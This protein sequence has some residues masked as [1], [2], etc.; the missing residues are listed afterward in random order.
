VN[1]LLLGPQG[2]GK[3][4]QAVRISAEYGIPH[5]STGNMLR[6]AMAAGNELGERVRPIYEAGRLVPDELMIELIRERLGQPDTAEGFVL[7]GF[8]RTLPQAEALDTML[9]GI[10]R[11]L[12]VILELIVPEE[13]S[14]ERMLRRGELEGR[15]DDT[16]EAIRR[17]LD[18]YYEQS[19]PVADHY[20][21][22]GAL[23]GIHGER[24]V[25][26]VFAE[27]QDV[28]EQ[29]RAREPA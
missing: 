1:I 29:A 8:P 22:T 19:A 5:V 4:T 15:S 16:L 20:R 14:V 9:A 27:I 2:S 23:V 25:D 24:S 21:A 17:R 13:V 6:D 18:A 11:E 10:G 12:D 7:D 26:E 28:L 3:G